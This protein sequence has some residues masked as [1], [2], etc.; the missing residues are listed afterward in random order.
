MFGIIYNTKVKAF[1]AL[2]SVLLGICS[3]RSGGN[4]A[5]VWNSSSSDDYR[6][7]STRQDK[8]EEIQ[9]LNE[10]LTLKRAVKIALSNNPA[11]S[12]DKWDARSAQAEYDRAVSQRWPR[13]DAA[14]DYRNYVNQQRL[15]PPSPAGHMGPFSDNIAS[16]NLILGMP[17]Y[18]GG[19]ITN[20]IKAAK[21]LQQAQSHTLARSKQELIFNVSSVYYSIL[22]QRHI[23]DSIEFSQRTLDAH[24]KRVK[25]LI[26]N[27]K[28][29]PVDKLRIEVRLSDIEQQLIEQK[30]AMDIKR[31]ALVTLMG[32]EEPEE[33]ITMAGELIRPREEKTSALKDLIARAYEQRSDYHSARAEVKARA[34]KIEIAEAR[35]LPEVSLVGSYGRNYDADDTSSTEEVGNIGLLMSVPLFTGGAIEADICKQKAQYHSA[36]QQLRKLKLKIRL[37]VKTAYKNLI[38]AGERVE[39]TKKSIDQ[40]KESLRIERLKYNSGKASITDVL[41]A[42]AE[43]LNADRNYYQALADYYISRSQLQLAKG[44]FDEEL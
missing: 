38:S 5:E 22:A 15:A 30:N 4:E 44:H 20:Q 24:L 3:C 36:E 12:A 23:I 19:Q 9:A 6:I 37:E 16:G 42:Q 7:F 28:A 27:E 41:D 43:L 25:D 32:I 29:A 34:H 1:I 33:S 31:E 13:L 14:G 39:A 21:L 11:I 2:L 18:T 17:L 8:P 10:P 35:G 40:G 26:A